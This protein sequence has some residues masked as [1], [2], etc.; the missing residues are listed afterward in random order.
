MTSLVSQPKLSKKLEEEIGKNEWD[1][2][3]SI[4]SRKEVTGVI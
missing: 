2:R 1:L 4:I 3:L